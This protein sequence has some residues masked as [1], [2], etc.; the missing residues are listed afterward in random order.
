MYGY[1]YKT[2][3]TVN[4]KI[5]IGQKKSSTFLGEAYLGSGVRLHSA[6]VHYGEDNFIVEMIDTAES[7]E[8]LNKK[9]IYY[10]EKFDARNQDTGYNIAKGGEAGGGVAWNKGLT[11]EQDPRLIQ[12]EEEKKKRA[13]SLRIAYREGRHSINKPGY[14]HSHGQPKDSRIANSQRQKGKRW[15]YLGDR[16]N[17]QDV[18]TV[19]VSKIEEYIEL[20]YKFGRPNYSPV[21]WNKGLT[22]ETDERVKKYAEHRKEQLNHQSIGFCKQR[23]IHKDK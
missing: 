10:I 21:A 20:G 23:S 16:N 12:S 5:Y 2:T 19:F 6:I 7:K 13:E 18:T 4:N 9:E 8:E 1:I 22:A 17:P 3:N 11:K 14:K 15:M